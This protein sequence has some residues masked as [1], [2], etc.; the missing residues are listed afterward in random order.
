MSFHS[1]VV[2]LSVPRRC[3]LIIGEYEEKIETL[4]YAKDPEIFN[5]V[6][7]KD[8][9]KGVDMAD[10]TKGS[11]M[12]AFVDGKPMF[13]EEVRAGLPPATSSTTA[14]SVPRFL[15]KLT[16][17]E[18]ASSI[19]LPPRRPPGF[20]PTSLSK[21]TRCRRGERGRVYSN[22]ARIT[23]PPPACFIISLAR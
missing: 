1:G 21:V 17:G 12:E 6:C 9:C 19:H 11:K 2:P 5:K 18:V 3:E 10:K 23:A 22:R 7:L 13:P 14:G 16:L 4:L 8:A 15:C 20:R